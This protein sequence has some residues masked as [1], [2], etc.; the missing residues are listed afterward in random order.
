MVDKKEY[1]F[2]K[3]NRMDFELTEV[4]MLSSRFMPSI[5]S[6]KSSSEFLRLRT[7]GAV[8]FGGSPPFKLDE[9]PMVGIV[10]PAVPN[11]RDDCDGAVAGSKLG[12]KSNSPRDSATR[13]SASV[14][15]S[16]FKGN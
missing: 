12:S 15:R 3:K 1:I 4:S 2:V 5:S 16:M 8:S 9:A 13:I 6:S 7:D 14:D 10:V 11:G